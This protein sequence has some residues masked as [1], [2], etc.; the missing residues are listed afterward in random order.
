MAGNRIAVEVD[1]ARASAALRR[2]VGALAHPAPALDAIGA[3]LESSTLLRFEREQ[4]P[5]GAPWKKSARAKREGGQTLTDTAR[6]KGSITHRV[7]GDS[8]EV[9]TNVVYGAIHQFGGKTRA[10]TIRAKRKKALS[11]LIG[12][13][14]VFAKSVRHPGSTIPARPFLGLDD[15]DR[16]A[17]ERIVDRFVAGAVG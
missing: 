2:L 5:G 3:R 16:A 6:L 7:V 12:G 1:D 8:V 10:R 9:G 4:A 14:R 17:I 11:F 15:T 13:R